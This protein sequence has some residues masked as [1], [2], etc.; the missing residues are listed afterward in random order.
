MTKYF[1]T[2]HM[3]IV[4]ATYLQW[5]SIMGHFKPFTELCR[6]LAFCQIRKIVCCAC[7]GNARNVSPASLVSDA[8]MHH[9]TYMTYVPWCMPGS[10][11]SGFILSRWRGKR[12][13]HPR[14]MRNPQ[15]CISGKRPMNIIHEVAVHRK[16]NEKQTYF[17]EKSHWSQV[18]LICVSKMCHH[19]FR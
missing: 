17:K 6:P 7:A 13:R 16:S 4:L 9:G 5:H 14:R 15:F 2:L 8:E 3:I 11:T 12:F 19:L 10:L 1:K 18:T